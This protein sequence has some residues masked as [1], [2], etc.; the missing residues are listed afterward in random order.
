MAERR[1]GACSPVTRS[2][3]AVRGRGWEAFDRSIDVH[4]GAHPGRHQVRPQ[5]P[6]RILTVRGVGYV[7]AKQPGLGARMSSPTPGLDGTRRARLRWWLA[8][9]SAVALPLC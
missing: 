1:P 2:R 7:F 6:R 5:T 3:E 4:A 9:F 8:L